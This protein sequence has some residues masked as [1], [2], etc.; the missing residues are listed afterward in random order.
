MQNKRKIFQQQNLSEN[1]INLLISHGHQVHASDIL[2]ITFVVQ[3]F[4]LVG[5]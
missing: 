2:H 1:V 3:N 5:K 4:H